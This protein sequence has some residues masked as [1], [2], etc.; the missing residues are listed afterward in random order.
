[1]DLH[2]RIEWKICDDHLHD[3]YREHQ[4]KIDGLWRSLVVG[5]LLEHTLK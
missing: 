2:E 3:L 4:K 5:Q 1:M